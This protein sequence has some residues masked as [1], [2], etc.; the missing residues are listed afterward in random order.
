MYYYAL[1]DMDKPN[2]N[3]AGV[4]TDRLCSKCK[5]APVAYPDTTLT[6]CR[7]CNSDRCREYYHKRAQRD[8]DRGFR[9]GV[10]AARKL[11]VAEYEYLGNTMLRA[12]EVAA[13]AARRLER[14]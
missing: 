10:E 11:I 12:S 6:L 7:K 5:E 1:L 13:L 9:E 14:P 4:A 3:G 2:G 8:R